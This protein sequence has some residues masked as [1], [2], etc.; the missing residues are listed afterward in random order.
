MKEPKKKESMKKKIEKTCE[1]KNRNMY[2]NK[3]SLGW[4]KAIN[5]ELLMVF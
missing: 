5:V 1:S 4:H 3:F 2:S